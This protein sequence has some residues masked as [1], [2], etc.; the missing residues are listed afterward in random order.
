L[1]GKIFRH[2]AFCAAFLLLFLFGSQSI[3]ISTITSNNSL[4]RE[5]YYYNPDSP[6]SNLGLLKQEFDSFLSKNNFSCTFQPFTHLADFHRL[7]S[8]NHPSFIMVPD[9]YYRQYGKALGLR[10]LLVPVRHGNTSYK[11]ILLI[12]AGSSG[13]INDYDIISF[14]MTAMGAEIPTSVIK[15]LLADQ[16][17]S[18]QQLNIINVP[19]DLDAILALVL[20]QVKM[21]L[22]SQD[23]L[24]IISDANPRIVQRIMKMDKTVTVPMPVICYLESR[25][26]KEDVEK[27]I[28]A[29]MKMAKEHPRN[30][31]MEMLQIDD[32]KKLTE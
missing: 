23:N 26:D 16:L 6:Q 7:S 19:K 14:A 17:V 9:W 18:I 15:G 25:V 1:A 4:P 21:A 30:K 3:C 2:I 31:I 11:K 5:F 20:G 28:T 12:A 27:F 32:W 8:E 22:V 13:A 24:Q 29:F 10:P